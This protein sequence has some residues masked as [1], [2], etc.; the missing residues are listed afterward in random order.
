MADNNLLGCQFS[1]TQQTSYNNKFF[2]GNK[3]SSL[4]GEYLRTTQFSLI[5]DDKLF[6]RKFFGGELPVLGRNKFLS[7]KFFT[8][9]TINFF[10]KDITNPLC[11]VLR[12]CRAA[13]G[14]RLRV[15]GFLVVDFP[16][17]KIQ[18]IFWVV[19]L[20]GSK[21][22]LLLLPHQFLSEKVCCSFWFQLESQN[23]PP[24]QHSFHGG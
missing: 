20:L 24:E 7:Y 12:A 13:C 22:F 23:F 18:H 9:G 10:A 5:V 19:D 3:T 21:K 2:A 6:G 15:M 14:A 8:S 17:Q 16:P 1:L 4:D 11:M